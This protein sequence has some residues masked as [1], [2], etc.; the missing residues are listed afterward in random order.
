MNNE[1][2]QRMKIKASRFKSENI[3]VH[4]KKFNGSWYNGTIFKIEE[5]SL[6]IND[7]EDGSKEIYFI[8]IDDINKFEVRE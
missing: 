8:D 3:I 7:R 5:N 1:H 6:T 2:E 4:L